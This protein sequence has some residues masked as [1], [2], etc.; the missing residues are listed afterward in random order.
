MNKRS[1]AVVAL[2]LLLLVVAL[3]F[4]SRGLSRTG[5]TPVAAVPTAPSATTPPAPGVGVPRSGDSA[6]PPW[7]TGSGQ[8]SSV[9]PGAA[10]LSGQPSPA[11]KAAAAQRESRE[12]ERMQLEIAEMLRD[13]K[14]PDPKR[15][16]AMLTSLKQKHGAIVAGVNLD[17]VLNNLQ[18]AQEIQTLALEIQRESSKL[19]GGDSKKMQ[20]YVAQLTKLQAQMRMD[21]TVP[22]KPA[23]AK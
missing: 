1:M 9:A 19:G 2:I 13:G 5:S 10:V 7:A 6:P 22:Q 12:L 4:G 17:V 15:V 16:A 21:I 11:D 20:A 3:Y 8:A 14:Q 18:V 23:V